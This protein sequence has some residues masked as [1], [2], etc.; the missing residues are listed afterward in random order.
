MSAGFAPPAAALPTRVPSRP[1]RDLPRENCHENAEAMADAQDNG[2]A[3][4]PAS[5]AAR[6]RIRDCE[7]KTDRYRAAIGAGG[8]LMEIT[9]GIYRSSTWS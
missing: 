6:Q 2:A 5:S 9:A 1:E 3:H 4:E 7:V 8:D